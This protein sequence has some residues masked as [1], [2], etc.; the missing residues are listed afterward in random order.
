MLFNWSLV[1]DF[2][3][4]DPEFEVQNDSKLFLFFMEIYSDDFALLS[5]FFGSSK[6][7][8]F[9]DSFLDKIYLESIIGSNFLSK[10]K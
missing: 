3:F 1:E 8:F 5:L 4:E 2:L 6:V 7:V 10:L 9:G